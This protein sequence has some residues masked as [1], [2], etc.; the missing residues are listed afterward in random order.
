MLEAA[1]QKVEARIV[2]LDSEFVRPTGLVEPENEEQQWTE[3]SGGDEGLHG[4]IT[5]L[6]SQIDKL[7]EE[8]DQMSSDEMNAEVKTEQKQ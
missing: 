3:E 2:D 5:D 4:M 7:K 8:L 6:R 1:V